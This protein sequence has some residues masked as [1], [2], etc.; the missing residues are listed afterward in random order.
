MHR[1]YEGTNAPVRVYWFNDRIEISNPGG[2]FGSVTI[3]NFGQPGINDYRNPMIA[4]MLKILGFVQR[5]GFGIAETRRALN[6]N[7]NPPVEFEVHPAN[8]LAI[9][10]AA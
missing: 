6:E 4:S 10:R 1:S 8:V 9:V 5:F 3:E 2:P 7:G